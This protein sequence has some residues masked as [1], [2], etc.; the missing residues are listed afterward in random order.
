MYHRSDDRYLER[1][2][3]DPAPHFMDEDMPD[4]VALCPTP[5]YP[6]ASR[7]GRFVYQVNT[8]GLE[9]DREPY[10]AWE[11]WRCPT[12]V[13]PA[14]VRCVGPGRAALPRVA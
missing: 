6:G 3:I 9:L 4:A 7:D 2:G 8:I 11:S 14:R 13:S 5:D 10:N 12:R 1:T